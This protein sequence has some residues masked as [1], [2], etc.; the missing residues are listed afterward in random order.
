MSFAQQLE[1]LRKS[2]NDPSRGMGVQMI[3][4]R[5]SALGELLY[6]FDRLD[7]EARERHA[8]ENSTVHNEELKHE[9]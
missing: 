5:R 3:R 1:H 9:S 4:V 6:H 7:A 2:V 8:V